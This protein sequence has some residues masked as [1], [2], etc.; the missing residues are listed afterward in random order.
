M[1]GA[2][3][4]HLPRRENGA[5]EEAMEE[6]KVASSG[7]DGESPLENPLQRGFIADSNQTPVSAAV[8]VAEALAARGASSLA[9]SVPR[10]A[11]A[12][13]PPGPARCFL[14]GAARAAERVPAPRRQ[15]LALPG[16]F[17]SQLGGVRAPRCSCLNPGG[18]RFHTAALVAGSP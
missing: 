18:T 9:R 16:P 1:T 8:G 17:L 3:P 13:A 10:C 7:W 11:G 4:I 15:P 2:L 12:L 6:W 5:R 14:G